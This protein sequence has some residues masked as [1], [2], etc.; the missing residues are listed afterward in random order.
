M[1][2]Q[3]RGR[4]IPAGP[5]GLWSGGPRKWHRG[6]CQKGVA[7]SIRPPVTVYEDSNGR[8]PPLRLHGVSSPNHPV[9]SQPEQGAEENAAECPHLSGLA[10]WTFRFLGF[11]TG[12]L[13]HTG[14]AKQACCKSQRR[15]HLRLRSQ[16]LFRH[17]HCAEFP[18]KR[19]HL[20]N[21]LVMSLDVFSAETVRRKCT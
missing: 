17:H 9:N 10:S 19:L 16:L 14:R 3:A 11:H 4:L 18:Q 7:H 21:S 8:M 1:D 15:H 20:Q 6:R 2:L 12:S 13:P 5:F